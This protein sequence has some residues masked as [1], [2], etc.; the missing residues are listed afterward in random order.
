LI[1]L[2]IGYAVLLFITSA[3]IGQVFKD[4]ALA[5]NAPE[6]SQQKCHNPGLRKEW[7]ALSRKTQQ[8]Y[9]KAFQCFS[10]LPNPYGSN[11]TLYDEYSRVHRSSGSLCRSTSPKFQNLQLIVGY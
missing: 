9:I 3:V 7:R 6:A 10:T 2:I 8:S 5:W 11:G 4:F 1:T